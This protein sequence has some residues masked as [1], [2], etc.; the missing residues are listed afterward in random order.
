MI[1]YAIDVA[2]THR[3]TFSVELA[4]DDPAVA[5]RLSLPVW[6]P[7]SYLVREFARHVSDLVAE[8]GGRAVPLRQLDKATWQADCVAGALLAVR[9]R[10]YAYDTSVRAAFLDTS[11]GFFNGTATC[12]RVEGREHEPHALAIVGLPE[13]WDIATSLE[14]RAGGTAH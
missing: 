5:Q 7:G 4:I 13:G 2:A 9:Y 12:L 11:R 3:H 6:I 10:V 8:Q 14:A 1:R